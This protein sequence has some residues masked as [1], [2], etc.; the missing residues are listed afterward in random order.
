MLES[1]VPDI[2]LHRLIRDILPAEFKELDD[3]KKERKLKNAEQQRFKELKMVILTSFD[4]HL[5]SIHAHYLSLP[6]FLRNSIID[7]ENNKVGRDDED[8]FFNKANLKNC[9]KRNWKLF[10]K[11]ELSAVQPHRPR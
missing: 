9:S 8:S 1:R 3:I 6:L 4:L 11:D 5:S 7:D 2:V 10:G